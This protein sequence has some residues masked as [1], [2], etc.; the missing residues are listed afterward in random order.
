MTKA[1]LERNRKIKGEV[2]KEMDVGLLMKE[3]VYVVAERW[4]LSYGQVRRIYYDTMMP[5]GLE[6]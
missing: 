5:E 3:A 1:R 6:H 2:Q 4:F